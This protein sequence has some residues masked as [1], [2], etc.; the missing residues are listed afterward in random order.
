MRTV[1]DGAP[2]GT[3]EGCR[4]LETIIHLFTLRPLCGREWNARFWIIQE[5]SFSFSPAYCITVYV[6]AHC[7]LHI[8]GFILLCLKRDK[9]LLTS[10]GD[11]MAC[12]PVLM[13]QNPIVSF[14]MRE[15][16]PKE[17]LCMPVG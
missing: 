9:K 12:G 16:Q 1:S 6:Q 7:Y 17:D 14:V 8:A 10:G 5:G 15:D 11:I 4:S 13:R 3:Y 2:V